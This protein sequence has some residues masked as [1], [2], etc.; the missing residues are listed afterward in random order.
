MMGFNG[1]E[2]PFLAEFRA[3]AKQ[4]APFFYNNIIKD[5][6]MRKYIEKPFSVRASPHLPF[7]LRL[8]W[9]VSGWGIHPITYNIRHNKNPPRQAVEESRQ[10][11]KQ[12]TA[13]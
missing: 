13:F 6:M 8:S 12:F 11:V 9:D 3:Q 5:P 1:V 4:K 2:P 7:S 10:I